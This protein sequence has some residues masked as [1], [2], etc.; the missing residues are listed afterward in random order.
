MSTVTITPG[1]ARSFSAAVEGLDIVVL[2]PGQ[3]LAFA[4]RLDVH[5]AADARLALQG[6]VAEGVDDLVV[7]LSGVSVVDATGLGVLVGA[8]RRAG[9]AGRRLVLADPSPAL[10]RVLFLT[11]LHRVLHTT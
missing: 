1:L 8:H 4:G 6:A 11:R 3:Q 7:D 10:L 2:D 5:Q 9:R